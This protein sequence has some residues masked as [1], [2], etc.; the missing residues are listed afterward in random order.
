M[1]LFKEAGVNIPDTV[2]DRIEKIGV[3]YVDNKS[4]KI[5]KSIIVRFT[6]FR[7][8]TDVFRPKK[9][10]EGQHRSYIRS[11]KKKRYNL[12]TSANK[13]AQNIESVKFCYIGVNCRPKIK[14]SVDSVNDDFFHSLNELRSIFAID[15]WLV[16]VI[17]Y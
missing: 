1:D 6:I 16:V 7:H 8:R 2:I 15:G 14:W 13:I 10:I 11:D 9:S 17:Y 4:K 5:W 3:A 12:I